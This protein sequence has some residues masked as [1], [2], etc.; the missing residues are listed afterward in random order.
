MR[1]LPVTRRSVTVVKI[2]WLMRN[3]SKIDGTSHFYYVLN[4]IFSFSYGSRMELICY[5]EVLTVFD[6]KP[7]QP[8]KHRITLRL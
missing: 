4:F 8:A 3:N 1:R 7:A 5:D 6:V 2:H